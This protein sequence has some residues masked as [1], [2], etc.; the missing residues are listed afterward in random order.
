MAILR[1]ESG[2]TYSNLDDI[3]RELAPLKVQLKRYPVG[4]QLVLPGLLAKDTLSMGEK[5]RVLDAVRG[6]FETVK[7]C[8]GYLW[9]DLMV[10]HPGSPN[11]YALIAQSDRCHT[12]AD[13][14][15]LYVLSGEGIFGFARPDGSQIELLVQAGEYLHIPAHTEHWFCPSARLHIKAARYFASAHG[16][17]PQ[18]THTRICFHV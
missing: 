9:R 2:K 5:A 15:A 11:L 12:H 3:S 8:E 16:W 10:V 6:H 4:N 13:S 17:V 7:R 14:E 18:Y 1:L